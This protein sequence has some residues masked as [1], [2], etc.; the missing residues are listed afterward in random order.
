MGDHTLADIEHSLLIGNIFTALIW[1]FLLLQHI[2]LH[3]FVFSRIIL[4]ISCQS[5]NFSKPRCYNIFKSHC[6]KSW[7][8]YILQITQWKRKIKCEIATLVFKFSF[9][10]LAPWTLISIWSFLFCFLLHHRW[11]FPFTLVISNYLRDFIKIMFFSNF[12]NCVK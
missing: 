4:S 9:W 3:S 11:L 8:I 10:Y 6:L 2:L 1:H 12:F 5:M 7:T